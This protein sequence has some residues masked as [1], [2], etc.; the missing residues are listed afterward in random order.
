MSIFNIF[1]IMPP[2]PDPHDIIGW[3]YIRERTQ[4]AKSTILARKGGIKEIPLARRKPLG[5]FR[6][7]VDK[8]LAE[9]AQRAETPKQQT[10][11][12]LSRKGRRQKM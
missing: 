3:E 6:G 5:W 7:H 11:R 1:L 2:L 8:W 10:R 12:L 4:L 9:C